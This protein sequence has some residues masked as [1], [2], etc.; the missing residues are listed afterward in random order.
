MRL[1]GERRGDTV[2]FED[3]YNEY[4]RDVFHFVLGLSRNA[5]VAEEI[6]QE[7][8]VRA[9]KHIGKYDGVRDHRAWLFTIA[10]NAWYDYCRR[11]RNIADVPFLQTI[12]ARIFRFL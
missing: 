9:I 1:Y 5:E 3:I 11:R 2:D 8:F 6:T 7:T 10:R 12:S 4:F